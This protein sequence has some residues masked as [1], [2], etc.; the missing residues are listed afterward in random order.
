M[1]LKNSNDIFSSPRCH[2][3]FYNYCSSQYLRG[4]YSLR[5]TD[6]VRIAALK[7]HSEMEDE[8]K[9]LFEYDNLISRR[10]LRSLSPTEKENYRKHILRSYY[11]LGHINRVE[12]RREILDILSK[13][14]GF[15]THFFRAEIFLEDYDELVAWVGLQKE[16]FIIV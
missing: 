6:I 4:L 10:K 15:N 5:S 3:I 12:A 11:R 9:Y 14:R 13:N 8:E 16:R 7:M 1:V 2:S